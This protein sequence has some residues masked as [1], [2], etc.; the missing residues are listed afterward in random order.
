MSRLGVVLF[1]LF[2]FFFLKSTLL[3]YL[4]EPVG[5]PQSAPAP[6]TVERNK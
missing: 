2:L 6:K 5:L 3:S 4:T 1:G